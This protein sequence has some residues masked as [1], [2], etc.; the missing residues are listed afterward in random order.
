VLLELADVHVRYGKIEALKGISLGVDEGEI[1]TLIGGNG[2]GKTTTLKTISGLRPVA[3][4]TIRL[5]GEDIVGIAPHR[6]VSLGVAHAPEGRGIFPG[7]TVRENLEIGAYGRRRA[8]L[9]PDL[10]RVLN[11]FPRLKERVKQFAGTLSGGEQ[12]M[13]AIG[14]ALMARPRL[15]L[16]DEAS[17]GL[18]PAITQAVFTMIDQINAQGVTVVLVEQGTAALGHADRAMILER[19]QIVHQGT[20]AETDHASLRERYLGTPA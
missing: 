5:R 1:V 20:G 7:M 6:L 17:L 3:A 13:L 15:L 2:A 9:R 16:I 12:Q 11:L 18:S 14:R 19:G 8:D 4:G 10:E